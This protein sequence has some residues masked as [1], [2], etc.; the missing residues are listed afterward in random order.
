MI[1]YNNVSHNTIIHRYARVAVEVDLDDGNPEDAKSKHTKRRRRLTVC[2][3][4]TKATNGIRIAKVY[5]AHRKG[6]AATTIP[7]QS[8]VKET[9]IRKSLKREAAWPPQSV[10]DST[11]SP[12]L[13]RE[14]T[15]D[16]AQVCE[17]TWELK[18]GAEIDWKRERERDKTP[19]DDD[20]RWVKR[21]AEKKTIN[22]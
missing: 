13:A 17:H 6:I 21:F 3:H 12:A 8:K 10:L 14:R 18:L 1:P 22:I 7:L 15:N 19:N 2:W 11:A 9:T 20:D 16:R 5:K 4:N